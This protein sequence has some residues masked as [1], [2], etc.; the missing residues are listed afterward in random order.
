MPSWRQVL[1]G[2]AHAWREQREEIEQAR[3]DDPAAAAGRRRARG[4]PAAS[5][6]RAS[7]DEAVDR[8]APRLRRRAR[9][10]GR[11]AEVPAG[12]GDRVPAA[13]R[14]ARDG[15]AHAARDGHAA[16]ST[17][18]SAAASRATRVDAR[19]IVPHFEKMLYDNALLARAYLHGWQVSGEPLFARVC[20]RDARLGAA[21]AAPGGGRLRLGARRRL[22]GRRGQVLRLDARRGARGAARRRARARRRSSTSASP[23]AGNFEGA[24]IPV[25]ATPDPRAAAPRS[26]RGLLAAREQR[27]RPGLDDKRLT[28]WNALMISAL[29][30]AGA[31]L[32]R[33]DYLDA[34]RAAADVPAARH[35]RRRRPPAAHLQPRR[36]PSSRAYLEDHAFLL[37]AL[38]TL[39]EATFERALV[40]AR[41]ARSPTR[42]I[43]RFADP[44][45]GGFFSDRRRPRAADR[46]AQGARGHAD[47]VR[48]SR[49]P[50]SGC[51]GSPR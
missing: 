51:C 4:R 48:R 12:V 10:L 46:A 28:A 50:R 24:S 31:V 32:E 42:S 9:R 26:R 43:E 14:R 29:A 13:P 22:R 6:T 34:A 41:R 25:R 16:A 8:A 2:V 30:E 49:P 36:R 3:R 18:R 5:S 39:Y 27:V 21:R 37:E 35:A 11:R 47:P 45:R 1:E 38:L 40:R 19:W 20:T 17:T 44:E 15:A 23:T 33:A 7:L